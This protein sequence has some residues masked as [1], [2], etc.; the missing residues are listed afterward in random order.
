MERSR[1]YAIWGLWFLTFLGVCQHSWYWP[2][3]PAKVATHFGADGQPNDWMSK[4]NA[5]LVL[6]GFQVLFPWVLAGLGRLIGVLPISVINIPHRE[7]WLHPERRDATLSWMG[8][9]LAWTAV[10]TGLLMTVLAHF[11]FRANVKDAGLEMAPF[12]CFVVGYL[13]V[14]LAMTVVNL[15]RF[16]LPIP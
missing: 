16:R 12:L 8:G 6:L 15:R 7:Y 1:I 9:Y 10:A 14:I 2:Q 13:V 4:E 11:T 3:L 5:T